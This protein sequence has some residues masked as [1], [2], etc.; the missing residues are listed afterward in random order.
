MCVS[1]FLVLSRRSE[2][3]ES[4]RNEEV[5]LASHE[6]TP[7]L[8]ALH[9]LRYGLK[10]SSEDEFC[11]SCNERKAKNNQVPQQN[12]FRVPFIELSDKSQLMFEFRTTSKFR[13]LLRTFMLFRDDWTSRNLATRKIK[14]FSWRFNETP[15]Y[16]NFI[17]KTVYQDE[18]IL[19]NR[20]CR[21]CS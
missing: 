5:T 12:I 6:C 2:W 13:L 16:Y 14:L 3:R 21:L 1:S 9:I 10:V 15:G 18:L 7:L 11:I 19:R 4:M 17:L 8:S 20:N